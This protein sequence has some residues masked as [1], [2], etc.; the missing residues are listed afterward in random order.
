MHIS[1]PHLLEIH[2]SAL[3]THDSSGRICS[4]NEPGGEPAPR[5]FLGRTKE[6]NSWRFRYDLSAN[7]VE[8]LETLAADEP[9]RD[10]LRSEPLNLEVLQETLGDNYGTQPAYSGPAYRFPEE[11]SMPGVATRIARSN[12]DLLRNM[13]T[14]LDSTA[15]TF[16]VREPVC[17]V[18]EDGFAVSLCYSSRLT[19]LVAEAGLETL[20]AY[21]GRGYAPAVVAAWAQAVRDTGRTP[22]YGTT[23]DNLASQAVARKL[24]LVQY[25]ADLSL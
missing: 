23:W 24:G 10:D 1:D 7:V 14:N 16:E 8:R 20:A 12:L 22:L 21:R 18:I 15:R 5:F 4:V 9:V 25:G 3:F 17:A 19:P 6:G 13:V 11:I 2:I